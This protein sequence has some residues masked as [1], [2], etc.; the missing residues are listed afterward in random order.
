MKIKIPVCN[1]LG[2]EVP[3]PDNFCVKDLQNNGG[4]RPLQKEVSDSF[5]VFDPSSSNRSPSK[6]GLLVYLAYEKTSF[7]RSLK[8]KKRQKGAFCVY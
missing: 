2:G 1:L 5:K 3:A 4:K 8:H 6:E 7:R